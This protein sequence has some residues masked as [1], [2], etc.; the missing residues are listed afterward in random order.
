MSDTFIK[1]ISFFTATSEISQP[2]ADATHTIPSIDFI[3]AEIELNDGTKGQGYLLSFH[4]SPGAIRGALGDVRDFVMNRGFD[5]M[6]PLF[7]IEE[8]TKETEYFGNEGILMWAGAIINIAMWDT[9]GKKNSKSIIELL[10][11]KKKKVPLYGSGGWLSYSDKELLDEVT[12]YKNRGFTAVKIKVGAKEP[13]RDLHRLRLVRE[14]VGKDLNIMM[15]AN[16][17]MDYE[18]AKE[19]AAGASKLGISW[20]E[21]PFD[22]KDFDSYEKLKK[23]TQLKLAMGEREYD[24]VALKALAGR[25]AIDLWQPDIIRI[26]GVERWLASAGLAAT[27]GIPTLPHFYKDYDVPLLC[28]ISTGYAVESFDWIDGLI[29]NP[30]PISDGFAWPRDGAGWGFSFKKEKLKTLQI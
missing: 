20:F 2:I 14:A 23:A 29:D 22:H 6:N 4:F 16:Q 21:E 18:S 3:I 26:G 30:M 19:L 5:A 25:K 27:W 17:G 1:N 9:M 7:F 8:W 12:G 13:G 10:G 28:A 24:L 15:D 11:G